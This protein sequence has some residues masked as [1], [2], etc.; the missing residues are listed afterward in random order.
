[1]SLDVVLGITLTDVFVIPSRMHV[2]IPIGTQLSASLHQPLGLK[3]CHFFKNPKFY[4]TQMSFL[5]NSMLYEAV[6]IF[7]RKKLAGLT[8]CSHVQREAVSKLDIDWDF[9]E[10]SNGDRMG[11]WYGLW[12]K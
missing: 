10:E 2:A 5:K 4:C 9:T 1:M 8:L 11:P 12:L 3:I 6:D 7:Y